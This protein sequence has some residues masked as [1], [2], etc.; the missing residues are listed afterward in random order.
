MKKVALPFGLQKPTFADDF[1][2]NI[3]NVFPPS[4]LQKLTFGDDFNQNM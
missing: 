4:G 3:E 1:N 2:Q